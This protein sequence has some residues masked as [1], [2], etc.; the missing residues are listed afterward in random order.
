MESLQK[1]HA[2]CTGPHHGRK[3]V[4][5]VENQSVY[6][7]MEH[8][9]LLQSRTCACHVPLERVE[10]RERELQNGVQEWERVSAFSSR[11]A[12]LQT[13]TFCWAL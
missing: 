13:E 8:C 2:A 9:L 11:S 4:S 6:L 10:K 5:G 1:A 3:Q 12:R 7:L